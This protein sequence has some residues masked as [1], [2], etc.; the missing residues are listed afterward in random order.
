MRMNLR[1]ELPVAADADFDNFAFHVFS[2]TKQA[3][4]LR[5]VKD[6]HAWF[7]RVHKAEFFQFEKGLHAGLAGGHRAQPVPGCRDW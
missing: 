5:H 6:D 1:L 4:A 3:L 2:A 7:S